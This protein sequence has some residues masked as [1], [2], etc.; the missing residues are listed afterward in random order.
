MGWLIEQEGG[1]GHEG[2][3][4][5]ITPDG[6]LSGTSSNAGIHIVGDDDVERVTPWAHVAGWQAVCECGWSGPRWER[7]DAL[8]T[9]PHLD[10]EVVQ[11][12]DGRTIDDTAHEAWQAHV[13]PLVVGAATRDA[14]DDASAALN[15][16]IDQ[17]RQ[18]AETQMGAPVGS[19][20]GALAATRYQDALSAWRVAT[21]GLSAVR[22][23][24]PHRPA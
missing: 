5:W 16:W 18:A 1:W 13:A 8:T 21:D 6:L 22:R 12:R 2:W 23:L 19:P 17:E 15:A 3:T 20:A 14:L 10:P 24:L 4:A 11:L 9:S 7:A